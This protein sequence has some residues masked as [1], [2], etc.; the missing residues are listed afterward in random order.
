MKLKSKLL[1]I[2]VVLAMAISL[3]G[4]G[5]VPNFSLNVLK[6]G[7]GTVAVNP[8]KR[9]FT[10]GEKVSITAV[11]GSNYFFSHFEVDGSIREEN[12][13]SFEMRKNTT[14]KAVFLADPVNPDN[15]VVNVRGDGKVFKS[16]DKS[17]YNIGDIVTLTAVAVTGWYFDHWEGDL[18]GNETEKIINL[19]AP[20]TVT[21]VFGTTNFLLNVDVQGEGTVIKS[22]EKSA[23]NNGETVTLTARPA[24]GWVF[25]HWEGDLSGSA[26]E[27]TIT[28]NTNK[29]VKAVFVKEIYSITTQSVGMGMIALNPQK[30]GYTYGETVEVSV[31]P[32]AGWYFD[33]WEGDLSGSETKKTITVNGNKSVTAFF[34]ELGS[35][36]GYIE[37]AGGNV[38]LV[39]MEK[40]QFYN[41]PA[42][43]TFENLKPGTYHLTLQ[44]PGYQ[45]TFYTVNVEPGQT[46]D[47]GNLTVGSKLK[48]DVGDLRESHEFKGSPTIGLTG[49]PFIAVIDHRQTIHVSGNLGNGSEATRFITL[50]L[51]GTNVYEKRNSSSS[52]LP[53]SADVTINPGT[54][55]YCLSFSSSMTLTYHK[56]IGYPVTFIDRTWGYGSTIVT[57][58]GED[59][60][61][62][63]KSV[64]YSLSSSPTAAGTYQTISNGG[65]VT[66]NDTGV[67][68]LHVRVIDNA[69]HETNRVEGP[70]I[71]P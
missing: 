35:I 56:D 15:L 32:M 36:S 22:P 64:Q 43:F 29:Y 69:G 65:T 40:T 14:V 11:P 67:W 53:Y 37:C 41:I 1:L 30:S 23:Y 68:Y 9:T 13:V 60:Y 25:D 8:D 45:S 44:K 17:G 70:Y 38:T 63:V 31:A 66:I 28:V 10:N 5:G 46:A 54:L 42:N 34:G 47:L 49:D 48:G 3:A 52:S 4:C 21:A 50:Y 6:E 26:A 18:S 24:V 39:E 61:S 7:E 12:P 55:E 16:P 51:N 59:A 27:A 19:D 71:I 33:H 57:V 62:G 2:M 58:S 20:K